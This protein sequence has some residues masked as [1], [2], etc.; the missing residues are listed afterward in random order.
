MSRR[1]IDP[2]LALISTRK[3]FHDLFRSLQVKSDDRAENQVDRP[4]YRQ[5]I[6]NDSSILPLQDDAILRLLDAMNQKSSAVRADCGLVQLHDLLQMLPGQLL[7]KC[8]SCIKRC[9]MPL[10]RFA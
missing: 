10:V 4:L 8:I 3:L 2:Q 6:A 9:S 1:Y 7:Y 5:A